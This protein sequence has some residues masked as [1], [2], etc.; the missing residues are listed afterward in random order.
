MS[1]ITLLNE[2]CMDIMSQY[3]DNYF[4][5]GWSD[6]PYFKGVGKAGYN[7]NRN[8]MIGVKRGNND[9]IDWDDQLPTPEYFKEF[10]RV[11]KQQIIWGINY[12]DFHHCTGRIVWDKVNGDTSFSD[13]EIA[14]CTA[15]N[16][17]K[18]FRYMWNGMCQ[19]KSLSEPTTMQ[20]NKKLN[21]KRIH[22]T[23][24]PVNL[25]KWKL[26]N[27]CTSDMRILDTHLGSGSSAIACHDFGINE[28]VGCEISTQQYNKTLLRFNQHTAQQILL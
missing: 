12:F 4:D 21:E 15:F 5:W 20:G 14:S 18:L 26:K 9:L 24:K 7:G 13:C 27:F 16:H 23:Q 11:T 8:S 2:N 25:Y 6:P 22:Q 10:L 1:K 28:F 3:P 19:A 17:V